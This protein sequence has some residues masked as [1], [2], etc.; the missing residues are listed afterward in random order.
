MK[1]SNKN[2]LFISTNAQYGGSEVLWVKMINHM[3]RS[4]IEQKFAVIIHPW[5]KYPSQIMELEEDGLKIYRAKRATSSIANRVL[6]KLGVK[7][8]QDFNFFI[9]KA[10]LSFKPGLAI[11]SVGDHTSDDLPIITDALNESNIPY[12]IL[13]QLANEFK[14][15]SD[16]HAIHLLKS[17]SEA[18][19][20]FFLCLK[21][22][23]IVEN[24]IGGLLYNAELFQSPFNYSVLNEPSLP[25]KGESNVYNIG[26]VTNLNVFHKGHDLILQVLSAKN[27]QNRNYRLNIY[28]T[29]NNIEL[30]KRLINI[31]KLDN[32]VKLMGYA[33]SPVEIW[34][35]NQ[36]CLFVS[37]M[38]GQS[39]AMI[40]AISLGRMI[41]TTNVGDA[42]NLVVDNETGFIINYPESTLIS[43]VMDKAWEKRDSW[44]KMG[45]EGKAR[46]KTIFKEDPIHK[47]INRIK[48]L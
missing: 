47:I 9:K 36:A 6:V 42:E 27:W 14:D 34:E 21:N 10:N 40:D 35:F 29:G 37:R 7:P 20:C 16:V 41:I 45:A 8:Q 17:Y 43:I 26:M 31:Y 23:R 44:L 32:K 5:P 19:K 13:V 18:K 22:K 12:V 11:V 30:I 25:Y 1:H 15:L 28:G 3:Y 2:L 48:D 24:H 39:L 38:E 4:D 46:L 33:E